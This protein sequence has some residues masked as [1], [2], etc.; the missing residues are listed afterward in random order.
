MEA[1]TSVD[2]AMRGKLAVSTKAG[3]VHFPPM[4]VAGAEGGDIM[5]GEQATWEAAVGLR[6]Y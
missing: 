4:T 3:H 5:A 6:I 1:Y 2:V